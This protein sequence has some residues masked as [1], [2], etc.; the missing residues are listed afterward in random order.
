MINIQPRLA[1]KKIEHHLN[2]VILRPR[3][4]KELILKYEFERNFYDQLL[5]DNKFLKEIILCSKDDLLCF[6]NLS[7]YKDHKLYFLFCMH[8]SIR[9]N[10]P[11]NIDFIKEIASLPK[12]VQL[13]QIKNISSEVQERCF[14]VFNY[15]KFSKVN[16]KKNQIEHYG[17][18]III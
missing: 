5:Y 2:K 3:K 10:P 12:D 4:N 16:K 7:F 8:E 13:D 17:M 15:D 9:S 11:F 1:Q 6:E 14:K 18:V